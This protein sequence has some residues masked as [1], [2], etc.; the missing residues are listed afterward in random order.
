MDTDAPPTAAA[1]PDDPA[2]LKQIN[3]ELLDLVGQ[4]QAKNDRLRQ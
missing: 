3:R 4:L 2:L 1:L